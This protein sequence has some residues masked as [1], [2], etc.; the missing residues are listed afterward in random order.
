ME[1][2]AKKSVAKTQT[3]ANKSINKI[4]K[5]AKSINTEVTDTIEDVV[6]D[7]KASRKEITALA[8]KTV[9]EAAKKVNTT[10][11]INKIKATAGKVN[12]QIQATANE[13]F[14]DVKASGKEMQANTIKMAKEAIEN[15]NITD[16]MDTVK[17]AVKNANDVTLE[18][19][20]EL[21]D[22]M[23]A[24]GEKWQNVAAKAVKTGLKI[25]EKQQDLMF[26][27]LEAVKGQFGTS[28]NRLRNIFKNN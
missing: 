27:T 26:S 4:A 2:T 15:V 8:T 7:V 16:R 5:T 19:A 10:K 9:K 12:T 25:A 3:V 21:V 22:G 18:T 11:N 1:N 14:E 23:F 28:A 6:A 17:K 20:E 13:I 24:N